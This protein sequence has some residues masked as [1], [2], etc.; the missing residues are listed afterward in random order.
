[1]SWIAAVLFLRA[2]SSMSQPG[3]TGHKAQAWFLGQLKQF[4]PVLSQGLHEGSQPRPYSVSP[5][6][7]GGYPATRIVAGQDYWLRLT[8]FE[9]KLTDLLLQA[10]LPGI[11]SVDLTPM[12]FEVVGQTLDTAKHEYAA[13]TSIECLSEFSIHARSNTIRLLFDTPSSFGANGRAST[14]PIP[15]LLFS[16]AWQRLKPFLNVDPA[17]ELGAFA[18]RNILVSD[19][20]LRTRVE[21]FMND[22]RLVVDRGFTGSVTYQLVRPKDDNLTQAE[23]M[24]GAGLLRFLSAALFYTGTGQH[25]PRGFGLTRAYFN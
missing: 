20:N 4:T 18:E 11:H 6:M 10:V 13:E 15:R 25:T 7:E 12:E 2:K 8:S 14:L 5:L 21:K 19:C 16:S 3:Y 24:Q 23:W 1:M 9:K 22:G 17:I